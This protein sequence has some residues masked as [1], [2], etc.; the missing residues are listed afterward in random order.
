MFPISVKISSASDVSKTG[1]AVTITP[2]VGIGSS[3]TS[4]EFF[5]LS[6]PVRQTETANKRT[7]KR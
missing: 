2:L 7:I 3:V 6:H 5:N 1:S 4:T